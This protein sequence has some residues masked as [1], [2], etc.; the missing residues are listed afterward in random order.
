[1]SSPVIQWG[2]ADVPEPLFPQKVFHNRIAAIR[3]DGF[4]VKL[5]TVGG[6]CFVHD[7][8]DGAIGG[9]GGNY[10]IRGDQLRV[11]GEGVVSGHFD[12]GGKSFKKGTDGLGT[13]FTRK[14]IDLAFFAVDKFGGM[15][16]GA[17]EGF[18]D[19]LVAEADA[20][21]GDFAGEAE[22]GVDG[23]AGGAGVTG[24]GGNDDVRG[25]QGF[26]FLERD[27]V[28]PD[29]FDVGIDLTDQLINI[30]DK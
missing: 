6:G 20:E 14:D 4:G 18:N 25:R 15:D 13:V 26:D 7:T 24:A 30:I 21:E 1:M 10:E 29:D 19:G 28:V 17:A 11:T 27:G 16:D 22:D 5:D 3:E 12:G 23:Y 8:H 9:K 2:R